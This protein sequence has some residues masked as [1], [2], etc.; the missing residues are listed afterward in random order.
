MMKK[1][2]VLKWTLITIVA[3]LLIVVSFGFWFKSLIP[4]KNIEKTTTL[5]ENLPYISENIQPPRGRGSFAINSDGSIE[6]IVIS[7]KLDLSN[8]IRFDGDSIS[9]TEN[10]ALITSLGGQQVY[11]L[12]FENNKWNLANIYSSEEGERFEFTAIKLDENLAVISG[13]DSSD[14]KSYLYL[15]TF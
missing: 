6:S 11:M 14:Y 10:H 9:M 1:N 12:E 7:A 5:V 15:H 2:P 4:P 8:G 3:I 13:T